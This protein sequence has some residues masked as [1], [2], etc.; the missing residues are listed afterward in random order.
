MTR[1]LTGCFWIHIYISFFH[2]GTAK[3]NSIRNTI[4]PRYN[5][6]QYNMLL[7]AARQWQRIGADNSWRTLGRQFEV[8]PGIYSLFDIRVLIVPYFWPSWWRHQ[9]ETFSALLALCA[10]NSPLTGEFPSQR[11]VTRSFDVF[12]DLPWINSWVNQREAG[13]LRR[14]RAHYI[15]TVMI[16]LETV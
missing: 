9:M 12:F 1:N 3:H 8:L 14:H 13:D 4:S 10:G 2:K 7:H 6:S 11:A 5:T 16:I 15:V